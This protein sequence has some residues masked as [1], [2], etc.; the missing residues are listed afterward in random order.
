VSRER[1]QYEVLK[2]FEGINPLKFVLWVCKSQMFYSIFDPSNQWKLNENETIERVKFVCERIDENAKEKKVHLIVA[3]IF[4]PLIDYNPVKDDNFKNRK[5]SSLEFAIIRTMKF[6]QEVGAT[7]ITL[8]KGAALLR[9]IN[10]NL[11]RSNVG[12][13]IRSIGK[14]W[15]YSKFLCFD[16]ECY[17][18]IIHQ[19]EPFVYRENLSETYNIKPILSGSELMKIYGVK[20]KDISPFIQQLISWQLENPNLSS[21]DYLN[22]HEL[23]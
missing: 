9:G 18:F 20:G 2:A 17:N 16:E 3:A 5:I 19:F 15:I 10:R 13:L 22:Q 7:C 12:Q 14:L 21:E 11:T 6:T 4:A 1:I 23:S 8:L